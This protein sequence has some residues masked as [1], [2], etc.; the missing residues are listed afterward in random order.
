MQ[1]CGGKTPKVSVCV[2]TYNQEKYIDHCLKSLVEQETDFE[3]EIIVA[4]DGSTD[5]TS[6]IVLDY[7]YRY[8]EMIKAIVHEKNIGVGENY[9][10]VHDQARGDYIAHMDGDD[11][12]L[13]G[14]LSLQAKFLDEQPECVMVFHRCLSLHC[15]GS[16]IPSAHKFQ[17]ERSYNFAEFLYRYPSSTWHSSKMYRR[18][19]KKKGGRSGSR[20]IDKHI[21]FEHGL[22]G[23]VGFLNQDLC[24]YRVGVGI[25]SNIYAVQ[26]LA[27]DSYNYAIDLGYDKKLVEK[28]I[29]REYFEQGLR[30]LQTGDQ[31]G[32]EKNIQLGVQSGYMTANSLLAYALRK[33]PYL[34]LSVRDKIRLVRN[35]IFLITGLR[36]LSK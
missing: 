3:F 27:L 1:H 16:L 10:F 31:S 12:A 18:A 35:K 22:R 34:Y 28:I 29:A 5:G 23:L 11:Y 13:P 9:T 8:P 19:A 36:E 21:H 30:V 17:V 24:V 20:F 7:A 26:E 15:D 6:N 14:K 32:F 2:M 25:S 4:D 33:F